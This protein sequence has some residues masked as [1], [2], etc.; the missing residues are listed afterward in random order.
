MT[1]VH[2]Q[3]NSFLCTPKADNRGKCRKKREA[4][5]Q[6]REVRGNRFII[7]IDQTPFYRS[8]DAP[9]NTEAADVK[10]GHDQKATDFHKEPADLNSG[11]EDFFLAW[12]DV[13]K[14]LNN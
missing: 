1:C 11:G 13:L 12:M 9:T 3:K 8:Q 4:Q 6:G 14:E 7:K 5:N 10:Q 2:C